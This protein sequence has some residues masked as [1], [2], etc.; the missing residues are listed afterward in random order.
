MKNPEFK[1]L[2]EK[3]KQNYPQCFEKNK[4]TIL[5]KINEL[6]Q[7]FKSH[8]QIPDERIKF[9]CGTSMLSFLVRCN[10]IYHSNV[11]NNVNIS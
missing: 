6:E 2:Y 7:Y 1:K 9:I 5:R 11:R 4:Q 10:Q 3:L 8:N